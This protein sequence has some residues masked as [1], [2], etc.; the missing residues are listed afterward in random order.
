[1]TTPLTGPRRTAGTFGLLTLIP[2]ALLLAKGAITP[3]DAGIRAGA[4]LLAVQVF[5]RMATWSLVH[6]LRHAV[7]AQKREQAIRASTTAKQADEGRKIPTVEE[8][9]PRMPEPPLVL[10][11]PG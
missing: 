8:N 11:E 3:L 2:I 1:M 6:V 10:P 5:V 9:G 4:A 7:A